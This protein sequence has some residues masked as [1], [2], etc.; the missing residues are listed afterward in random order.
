VNI[1]GCGSVGSHIAAGLAQTGSVEMMRLVDDQMLE[2]ENTPRHYCG[3]SEVGQHKTK[4]TATKI[5]R[6]FPHLQFETFEKDVLSLLLDAPDSLSDAKLSIV[7]IGNF[8]VERRLNWLAT[9]G[10]FLKSPVCFVWV[11]PHLYAGHALYINPGRPGCFECLLDDELLFTNRII[12][13]AK[14]FSRREAGCQTT[15]VPYSGLDTSQFVGAFIKFLLTDVGSND[16]RV[17]SWDGDLDKARRERIEI[18][19]EWQTASSYSSR[20]TILAPNERCLVCGHRANTIWAA[21]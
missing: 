20:T 4:A 9:K 13:D 19:D 18:G 3:I 21:T 8:A 11:E 5:T 12:R 10:T 17:F 1:I 2:V 6:H 7:A 14:N 16:N 15:F